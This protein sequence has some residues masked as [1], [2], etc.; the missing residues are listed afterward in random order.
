M[1]IHISNKYVYF[2]TEKREKNSIS[3]K[4]RIIRNTSCELAKIYVY[5]INANYT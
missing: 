4:Q 5:K 2:M 1:N 3:Y